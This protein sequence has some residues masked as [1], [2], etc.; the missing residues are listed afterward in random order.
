MRLT[1]TFALLSLAG[2]AH[3]AHKNDIGKKQEHNLLRG[4]PVSSSTTT[5][6]RT[7]QDDSSGGEPATTTWDNN[8]ISEN[9]PDGIPVSSETGHPDCWPDCYADFYDDAVDVEVNRVVDNA[10]DNAVEQAALQLALAEVQEAS[11]NPNPNPTIVYDYSTGAKYDLATGKQ[12]VVEEVER[13]DVSNGQE[14]INVKVY[15]VDELPD[16]HPAK[17]ASSPVHGSGPLD[18]P[19]PASRP[20]DGF[21]DDPTPAAP[22]VQCTLARDSPCKHNADCASGCCAVLATKTKCVEPSFPV[23][24]EFCPVDNP[25][26]GVPGTKAAPQPNPQLPQGI[27]NGSSNTDTA[28]GGLLYTAGTFTSFGPDPSNPSSPNRVDG[29]GDAADQGQGQSPPPLDCSGAKKD[30][31]PINT[32]PQADQCKGSCQCKSGCCV[33]YGRQICIDK[34]ANE[35]RWAD[36]CI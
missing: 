33:S 1:I 5:S 22:A 8:R 30:D 28:T 7:L 14:N 23:F 17:T 35:G 32:F 27:P 29:G 15:I 13:V 4:R 10:A 36:K 34:T 26:G 21:L 2:T 24:Q 19:T 12:I 9:N 31:W 16:D 6:T 20:L 18:D 11:A 25:C 3:A